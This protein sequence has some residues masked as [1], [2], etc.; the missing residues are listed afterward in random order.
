[1]REKLDPAAAGGTVTARRDRPIPNRK[2]NRQLGGEV[3][4]SL[5]GAP[6]PWLSTVQGV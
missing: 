6:C 5:P 3:N 1:M 4:S 2:P